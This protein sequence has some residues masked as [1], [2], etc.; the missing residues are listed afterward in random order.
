MRKNKNRRVREERKKN[1]RILALEQK[2]KQQQQQH[3]NSML[4][5]PHKYLKIHTQTHKQ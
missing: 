4:M 5:I 2:V 1:S 3:L